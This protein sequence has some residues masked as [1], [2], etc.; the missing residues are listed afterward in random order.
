MNAF[1]LTERRRGSRD[2]PA[3]ALPVPTSTPR[4][5]GQG[6][7]NEAEADADCIS[8]DRSGDPTREEAEE[9][10]RRGVVSDKD[11]DDHVLIVFV[12]VNC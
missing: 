4:N 1:E 5:T 11:D 9:G 12:F 7:D 3:R 2:A 8:M 6:G 10:E